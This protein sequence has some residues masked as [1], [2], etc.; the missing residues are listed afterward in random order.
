MKQ[1]H[2]IFQF[3]FLKKWSQFHLISVLFMKKPLRFHMVC[4]SFWTCKWAKFNRY[5]FTIN[6]YEQC[7][8]IWMQGISDGLH[9]NYHYY[10]D[11]SLLIYLYKIKQAIIQ[12]FNLSIAPSINTCTKT[13]NNICIRSLSYSVILWI[14]YLINVNSFKSTIQV[15]IWCSLW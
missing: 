3:F 14:M 2:F 4:R 1:F 10:G 11:T 6:K 8:Q 13:R 7:I 9:E 5:Q 12:S 15:N